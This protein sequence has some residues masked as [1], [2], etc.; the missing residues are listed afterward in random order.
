MTTISGNAYGGLG[1][2]KVHA[3]VMTNL[4]SR[5]FCIDNPFCRNCGKSAWDHDAEMR[6]PS[7]K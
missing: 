4:D 6:C 2:T 3:V 7:A 1:P 5:H